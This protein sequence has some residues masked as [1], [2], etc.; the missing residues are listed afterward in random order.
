[1][2]QERKISTNLD[3]TIAEAVSERQELKVYRNS[4]PWVYSVIE[5]IDRR[6]ADLNNLI[7]DKVTDEM[8]KGKN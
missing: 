5:K 2:A 6:L 7:A 1:M 8:A 3:M 4:Q